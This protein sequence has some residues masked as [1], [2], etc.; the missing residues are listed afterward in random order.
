[1]EIVAHNVPFQILRMLK[2]LNVNLRFIEKTLKRHKETGQVQPKKETVRKRTVRTK[3][4]VKTV[5]DGADERATGPCVKWPKSSMFHV[6]RFEPL[7]KMRNFSPKRPTALCFFDVKLLLL[8]GTPQ[9]TERLGLF[10]FV[11]G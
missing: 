6:L 7:V 1:M 5:R 10:Y 2:H 8:Q 4:V 11:E 9:P 3:K